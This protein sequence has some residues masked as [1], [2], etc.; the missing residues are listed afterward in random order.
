VCGFGRTGKWFGSDTYGIRPDLMTLA[1]GLSSGYLPI[2]ALMVGTRVGEVIA[3]AHEELVHGFTY[4]GHPTACAV[5]LENIRIIEAENLVDRV[6][7]DIGPY[8]QGR[9]RELGAH[10]LIGEVRGIGL[11]AGLEIVADKK[12]RRRFER[13]LDVG[14]ICREHCF[15]N[16]L[17]MRAVRDTMVLAPPLII[18]RGEVDEL[19]D[20][21][22]L[23]FD[24][25]LADLQRSGVK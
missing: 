12:A 13:A 16:G 21:A 5:A 15:D 19:I 24:L 18:S 17:V 20:K 8:F 10:P 25:T 22:R 9:L 1:K 23:C 6:G 3:N 2:A 4:S 14:G 7:N 11:I